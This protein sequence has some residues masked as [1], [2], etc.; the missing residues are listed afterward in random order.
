M[1]IGMHKCH[2][3][4]VFCRHAYEP[5]HLAIC[6]GNDAS[7]I[8][9]IGEGVGDFWGPSI[10]LRFG[11]FFMCPTLNRVKIHLGAGAGVI[12]VGAD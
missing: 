3:N 9:Q 11:V 5:N 2:G 12:M 10:S 6:F 1:P 4:V 7:F 8:C